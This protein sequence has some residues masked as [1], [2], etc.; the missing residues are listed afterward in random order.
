MI[1]F[2]ELVPASSKRRLE[3]IS[4]TACAEIVAATSL[5]NDG[6]VE[7]AHKLDVRGEESE[8]LL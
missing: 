6:V 4:T 1:C 5:Q 3:L 8:M 7:L 2:W